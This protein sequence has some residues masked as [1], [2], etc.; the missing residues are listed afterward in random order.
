MATVPQ[1]FLAL[2]DYLARE[3]HAPCK[4]EYFRGE[5][6]AMAGGSANHAEI[7]INIAA[8]LK[9]GLKGGPCRV[10]SNDLRVKS[11]DDLYTYPDVTVA[12]GE[13]DYER[14]AGLPTL[15]NPTLLVEVS[16]E[17]TE[18]YDRGTKFRHYQTIPS[19]RYYVIVSQNEVAVECFKR[20]PDETWIL[21]SSQTLGES[22]VLDELR[23]ELPLAE[24]YDRIVFPRR[25]RRSRTSSRWRRVG[26]VC[27]GATRVELKIFTKSAN[28]LRVR[29]VSKS[30]HCAV[31]AGRMPN[32]RR[33]IPLWMC[34]EQPDA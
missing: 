9:N 13:P 15:K 18:G 34:H 19:L 3:E 17:S 16:S 22:V 6:F 29:R 25:R 10:F 12:C 4:S 8:L 1:P 20:G 27:R 7:T 11:A 23:V 28:V 21:R 30:S 24:I 31:N 14:R 26:P 5:A 33:T 32:L 2:D